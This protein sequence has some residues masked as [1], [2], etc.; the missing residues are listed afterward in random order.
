M[1]R[2]IEKKEY[3]GSSEV[4]K[5]GPNFYINLRGVGDE[6]SITYMRMS[7]TPSPQVLNNPSNRYAYTEKGAR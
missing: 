2:S 7:S 3:G 1:K 4:L 5:W 6:N